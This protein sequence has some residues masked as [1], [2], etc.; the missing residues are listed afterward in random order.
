MKA[1]LIPSLF[2]A[3]IFLL[4][5]CMVGPNYVKPSTPMA[6]AFKEESSISSQATDG[7]KPAQPG[8]Q[9]S[10]G[11]WWEVYEDPQLNGLEA[12]I[13]AANQTLKI[14]EANYRQA[15]TAIRFNR[16]YEAPTIGTSPSISTV[17]DSANQPYFPS[18]LANNGSGDFTL[19][20]D[21]SWE[22]DLWGRI[23]RSVTAAKEQ[24]QA[25]A[26]DMAAVQLSLQ[27][28][29]AYDYF[30]LRS[31]D[32]EKKLLDDTVQA[33]SR[34]LGLTENRFEGGAAPKS[35]VAQAR[36]QLEDAQVLDTDIMVQRAEYEHAIAILIGKPP[37]SFSLPPSP[38]DLKT[39]AIPA[40]P[41]VLPSDL[42]E[43]RPDIAASERRMAAANEQIGI[44]EA[45]YYP[46]LNL[47]AIAGLQGTSALNWFNWP[48]R[49][50]AV[51]PSFSETLFDAGRRRATKESAVAGY[52]A[53][54]ATYRQTTLTAFQQV[55]DNLAV[56][57]ILS[58]ESQQQH[59]ATAAAEET[60]RLFQN[61]YAGGVDTYL[62]V[63]T[64][65]TTALSNERNDIDIR[66][67]QLDASV[68]LIKALGGDWNTS[69]LPK[70]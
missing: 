31:A 47:S 41:Q 32:A 62:Q 22:I 26:A 42:L 19:P 64:S 5:G 61:R 12:Q 2:S 44:A 36:T 4:A 28:E 30:E 38:I 16:S 45:A 35:D 29:L 67:R 51:G 23:R 8:D 25:S 3:S 46:T 13:D 40:V 18:G 14:A 15:R 11:N 49:F 52:D 58:G 24:T 70:V 53:N 43:R 20:V 54:V 6:P 65:Q 33:Y 55:E 50:W 68:L 59:D 48:S 66:R 56:L 34:A 17:R 69:K 27:A 60:L 1:R 9:T 39:T 21:L 10:R 37:A 63:V 57:R 7:W